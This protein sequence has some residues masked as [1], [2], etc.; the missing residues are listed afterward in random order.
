MSQRTA[1]YSTVRGLLP[2]T[3]FLQRLKSANSDQKRRD[4][5]A[6]A[7][8]AELLA[9]VEIAYNVLHAHFPLKHRQLERLRPHAPLVRKLSRVR[10]ERSARR[11]VQSGAGVAA[12]MPIITPIL[13]HLLASVRHD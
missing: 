12:L 8:G 3:S 5:V 4:L 9:L 7:T 13:I 6:D 1:A 2:V 10:S 11:L